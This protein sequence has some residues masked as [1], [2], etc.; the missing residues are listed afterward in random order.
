MAA[1]LFER[2]HGIRAYILS[3]RRRQYL[4][5][6]RLELGIAQGTESAQD[7]MMQNLRILFDNGIVFGV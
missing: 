7:G 3:A 1:Q 4:F 2:L 5:Y 6:A